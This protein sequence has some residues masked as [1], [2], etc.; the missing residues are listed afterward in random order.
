MESL[1]Q[2]QLALIS[3]IQQLR[4]ECD[5]LKREVDGLKGSPH[6]QD[7]PCMVA[8]SSGYAGP[9]RFESRLQ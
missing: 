5:S 6:H 2:R 3:M 7:Q 8:G 1:D 4:R 9:S